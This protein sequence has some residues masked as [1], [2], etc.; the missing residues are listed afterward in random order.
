MSSATDTKLLLL[1][2]IKYKKSL[3]NHLNQLTSEYLQLENRWR[4][5]NAVSEG[6]YVDQFRAGW[7]QTEANF[8]FYINQ[9]QKVKI[10]LAG[11]IEALIEF[12]QENREV[13]AS[14]FVRNL[15]N[16]ISSATTGTKIKGNST[17][18]RDNLGDVTDNKIPTTDKFYPS[19]KYQAHH[20]VPGASAD[21]SPLVGAAIDKCEFDLDSAMNGIYLPEKPM[22][23]ALIQELTG[24]F[25]PMHLGSHPTYN[26]LVDDI[27]D[28]HWGELGRTGKSEDSQETL[29]TLSRAIGVLKDLIADGTL[30]VKDP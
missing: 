28:D 3:E 23:R 10:L 7:A 12:N 30:D 20:V 5:F 6:D 4:V 11:R 14:N 24:V 13:Y 17:K 29:N 16:T 18:L 27:L 26:K 2:L 8:N 25:L 22:Q 19:R 1:R 15:S 21:K 9:A